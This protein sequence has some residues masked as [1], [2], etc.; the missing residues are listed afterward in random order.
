ML[1]RASVSAFSKL[2]PPLLLLTQRRQL[3]RL[4]RRPNQPRKL[5]LLQ[6]LHRIAVRGAASPLLYQPAFGPNGKT[7]IGPGQCMAAH[8]FNAMGQFRGVGL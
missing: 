7:H 5:C 6:R 4:K 2:P 1:T 3:P 8:G